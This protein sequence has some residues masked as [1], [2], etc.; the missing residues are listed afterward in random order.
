[1]IEKI[2]HIKLIIRDKR[3]LTKV[4]YAFSYIIILLAL[5]THRNNALFLE[6]LFELTTV[7]LLSEVM[8][9]LYN[10]KGIR[11]L[12]GVVLFIFNVE[13]IALFFANSFITPTMFENLR[14]IK[15]LGGKVLPYSIGILI[16]CL[17]SIM[18]QEC[19][20]PRGKVMLFVII[21][22]IFIL[23]ELFM[24]WNCDEATPLTAFTDVIVK[25]TYHFRLKFQGQGYDN[26][27]VDN[28]YKEFV[29]DEISQPESI[30]SKPNI[31]VIFT[32]GLSSNIIHDRNDLMPNI[33]SLEENSVSF[34]RYYNHTF[35]TLRGL[36][37]Q[38]YSCYQI[39]DFAINPLP[40]LQ[41][42]LKDNGY[43]TA[44]I[45]TEPNNFDFTNYLDSM[46][47]DEIVEDFD[48]VSGYVDTMTDKEAYDLLYDTAVSYNSLDCPFFLGIYT[49]GTHATF[50]SQENTYA[51]G[52]YPLL[53]KFHNLDV[54][55]GLFFDK[56][57]KTDL[58]NNTILIFTTDHATYADQDFTDAFPECIRECTDVDEIPLYIYYSGMEPQTINVNGSNSLCFTPTVLDFLDITGGNYF[59]GNSLFGTS[60]LKGHYNT[61]FYDA[62]YIR[63]TS[64]GIIKKVNK[65]DQKDFIDTINPF[66]SLMEGNEKLGH[67]ATIDA[68][69]DR[70]NRTIELCLNGY[71][72]G[73]SI[74]FAV[75]SN[76]YG[77]DDIKWI[78]ANKKFWKKY[79]AS[80]PIDELNSYGEI[81]IHV[82]HGMD[83]VEEYLMS[84]G[85]NL[86]IV[87]R[88]HTE[89]SYDGTYRLNILFEDDSSH[90]SVQFAIWN[91]NDDES[92][93]ALY[94]ANKSGEDWEAS[95]NLDNRINADNTI[96]GLRIYA[97]DENGKRICLREIYPDLNMI[98]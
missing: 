22:I 28:F 93:I 23:S 31:I 18:P 84:K 51:D 92:D 59:L 3:T 32:E 26:K 37:G 52:K 10:T 38:L 94:D 61:I 8:M 73:D 20:I 70:N 48:H 43:Y 21:V 63:S 25:E 34:E 39:D 58:V 69:I 98:Y 11:L 50:D 90:D 96:I 79:T 81:T 55:W 24:I 45:N 42:I 54:Q 68:D 95:I 16:V 91:K 66:F 80:I 14:F 35:A 97:I 40:S 72:G 74:W 86:D 5:T 30:K 29:D 49:F 78:Q 9:S 83:Q 19:I 62:S 12:S 4:K 77:Q 71:S 64:D 57:N 33:I 1:M 15:D 88:Y 76:Q 27:G 6:E 46:K 89:L 2:N 87:P 53:N 36:E 56:F 41:S 17:I 75:W 60:D 85:L 82:F 13:T 7:I 67:G 44:F 65:G 47:F